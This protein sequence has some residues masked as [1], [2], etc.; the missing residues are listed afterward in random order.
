VT[1]NTNLIE[2]IFTS[3]SDKWKVRGHTKNFQW[4]IYSTSFTFSY[5]SGI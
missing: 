5:F 2:A 3:P 1:G 4:Q